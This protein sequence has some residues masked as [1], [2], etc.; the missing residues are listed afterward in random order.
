VLVVHVNVIRLNPTPGYSGR[1]STWAA[2]EAFRAVLDRAQV[3]HTMR[4]Q[5]GGV[6]K[7]GCGQLRCRER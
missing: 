5:R 1:P 4:Q 6:I 7:A 3:L 2:I